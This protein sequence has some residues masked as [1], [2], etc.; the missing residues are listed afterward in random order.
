MVSECPLLA[1]FLDYLDCPSFAHPPVP[2]GKL[3]LGLSLPDPDTNLPWW[4]LL[5]Q[6]YDPTYEQHK[7]LSVLDHSPRGASVMGKRGQ[8]RL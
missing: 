4:A 2:P 1:P 6:Q 5:Q 8:K 3:G 7:V